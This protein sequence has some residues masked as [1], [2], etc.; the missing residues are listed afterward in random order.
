MN[1]IL[2]GP[3]GAGKGTQSKE[4]SVR[5]G[6]PQLSTGDMLRSAVKSGSEIG[7]RAKALMETGRLVPDEIVIGIIEGRI[8]E[9]DC[10]AGFILDGFPRTLPQASA[11]EQLLT[12][13]G[14]PLDAVIEMRVVD[15]E[16]VRR[17][18]GRFTCAKCSTPFHDT[19][20]PT[21][22]AGKCDAC[23]STDFIRRPDD[24]AD[25]IRTRLLVYYRETSPLVGFYYAKGLLHSIDGMAEIHEVG[26]A[27]EAILKATSKKA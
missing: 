23:G 8:A 17:I 18:A 2:L 14:K 19:L 16:I 3:P 5:H 13:R 15:D 11:L 20:M 9:A 6:I 10:K 27:I 1:I 7:K 25:A 12:R 22:I 26:A 4:L 24:S 21:K